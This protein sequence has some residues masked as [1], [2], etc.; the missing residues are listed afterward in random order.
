MKEI[1]ETISFVTEEKN[2]YLCPFY[3]AEL[4]KKNQT[5]AKSSE[6][7]PSLVNRFITKNHFS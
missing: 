1:L 6:D 7:V 4:D 5:K 3:L 2:R